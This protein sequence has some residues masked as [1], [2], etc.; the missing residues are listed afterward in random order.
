MSILI[1]GW[2]KPLSCRECPCANDAGRIC[3]ATGEHIPMTGHVRFCPIVELPPHGRLIDA[4]MVIKRINM[5]IDFYGDI[6]ITHERMREFI[7]YAPTIVE[8]DGE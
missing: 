5:N 6:P 2:T 1:K 8:A 4:D 3:K 7:E